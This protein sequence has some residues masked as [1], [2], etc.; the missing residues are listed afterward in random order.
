M[1][2]LLT[3]DRDDIDNHRIVRSIGEQSATRRLARNA[4]LGG[5][6]A[7]SELN[8]LLINAIVGHVRQPSFDTLFQLTI[9]IN[10]YRN[11][12]FAGMVIAGFALHDL[13]RIS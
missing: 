11:V 9:E 3:K 5:G 4:A 12:S 1:I 7:L 8:E 6:R 10:D 2:G 13:A